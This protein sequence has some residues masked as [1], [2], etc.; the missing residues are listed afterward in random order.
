[1]DCDPQE[2]YAL[3]IICTG[4]LAEAMKVKIPIRVRSYERFS[5]QHLRVGR[6]RRG[7]TQRTKKKQLDRWK[8][9]Q[10]RAIMWNPREFQE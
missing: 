4:M 9:N 10:N 7:C 3:R 6:E 5:H 1:M 8:E 2:K